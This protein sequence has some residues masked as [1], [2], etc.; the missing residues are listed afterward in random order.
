[1][2]GPGSLIEGAAPPGLELDRSVVFGPFDRVRLD[3]VTDGD[4]LAVTSRRYLGLS[5][6]LH[7]AYPNGVVRTLMSLQEAAQFPV[8]SRVRVRVDPADCRLL[9]NG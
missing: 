4:G 5:V 1:M 7:I 3:H 8:G 2:I 6:E 9:P